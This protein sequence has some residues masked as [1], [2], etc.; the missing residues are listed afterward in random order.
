[1]QQTLFTYG[2]HAVSKDEFLQAYNKNPDT[3]GSREEKMKQYLDLYINFRLKLQA[4][5]DEKAEKDENIKTET[6]NFKN[7]LTENF[8]NKQADINHLMHEAFLRSQKDILVKQV[9]VKFS[10][11]ADTTAAYAEILKAYN[12]LKAGKNF[13]DI[14]VQYSNDSAV[15]NVRGNIGY[16]TV[17]TLPYPI[18]N[19]IYNLE[20]GGFSTIYKSALGYHILKMPVNGLHLAGGKL[21][22]L[23]FRRLPFIQPN[24]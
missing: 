3:A 16:I 20:P 1:M 13:E 18:E 9:F 21:S 17:F 7:Q 12:E 19:I 22:N 24:R 14:S 10:Q 5:Y 15:K 11:G 2:T 4:A 6:E 8:I 23:Y